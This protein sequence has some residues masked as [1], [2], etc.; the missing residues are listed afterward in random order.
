MA[1]GT[2]VPSYLGPSL[3]PRS[4]K[5]RPFSERGS[6]GLAFLPSPACLSIL[7]Q[8]SHWVWKRGIC[9]TFLSLKQLRSQKW[10]LLYTF[11]I[12]FF[13]TFELHAF[14]CFCFSLA[15]FS[16]YRGHMHLRF[17][18]ALLEFKILN[19]LLVEPILGGFTEDREPS[20]DKMCWKRRCILWLDI[21]KS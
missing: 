14:I 2:E 13:P 11:M 9:K 15:S 1:R 16:F 18:S 3:F 10:D 17:S 6:P 21:L 4:K 19:C 20:T 8:I 5:H 12:L 7:S